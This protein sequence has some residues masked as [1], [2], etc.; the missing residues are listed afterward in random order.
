M[1]ILTTVLDHGELYIEEM[2]LSMKDLVIMPVRVYR[3]SLRWD[4]KA[5][6]SSLALLKADV[7]L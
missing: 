4:S 2:H 6:L 1:S 7:G 5:E 3:A